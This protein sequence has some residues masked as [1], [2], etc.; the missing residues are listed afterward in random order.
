[1]ILTKKPVVQN[2][3]LRTSSEQSLQVLYGE[4][5]PVTR[6][7]ALYNAF[8]YPTKIS[9]EAIALYIASHTEPEDTVFD[10]FAGS[11]TTGLAALLCG[12]PPIQLRQEA[13]RLGLDPK[14]GPRNAILY[15][16]NALGAFVSQTLT[17]PPDPRQF[18]EAASQVL[19]D[20]KREFG[21]LYSA[22]DPAGGNGSIRY[23]VWSDLLLCSN[24]ESPVG[25][26][27]ECVSVNPAQ[28]TSKFLCPS[29]NQNQSIGMLNR[30]LDHT[31]DDVL[32]QFTETRKRKMARIYG[33]SGSN[34]WSR[35]PNRQDLE[36]LERVYAEDIPSC[37]PS[38][39]IPWGDLYRRGYHHG[40]SHVHHFYTRRN[41]IA[42]GRLWEK[43]SAFS[44]QLRD[45]LRFWLLSYNSSHATIMSRVIAKSGQRDLVVTGAQ[46]GVLYVSGLPVEKNV[47]SGL[48]RKLTSIT[49]AFN[50]IHGRRGHVSVHEKSSRTI[51]LPNASVDYIFADPPFGANI[52]YSEIS[53]LNES[54]LGRT[55]DVTDEA[56]VS[57]SQRKSVS[58]YQQIL[59]DVFSEFNRILK[60]NGNATL[61]FHSASSNV[62]N[63]LRE[64]YSE[65]GFS[66]AQ[67]GILDKKQGSFKQV[68]TN[69]SVKGDP[70]LLL[71]KSFSKS[72]NPFLADTWN[73]A[74][75]L[76][77]EA[78]SLE[79]AEQTPERLYSRLVNYFLTQ[80][81][82]VPIDAHEYYSWLIARQTEPEHATR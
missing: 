49:G 48:E 1:M 77:I 62:W 53:I 36:L 33:A 56:I 15:E 81:Q 66:V 51:A 70:I 9:P 21:W 69:G 47:F 46:P 26:W 43:A 45:A 73:I 19:G 5:L 20:T 40:I 38:V 29:C 24:C 71:R 55:T 32:R 52:P 4:A 2:Q 34:K 57:K 13:F 67:T 22:S 54:W 42:F 28:I 25:L 41:L 18:Q 37:V 75:K 60:P 79:L 3:S 58:N 17:N 65:A 16:I 39:P 6:T 8:P 72:P 14:W 74:E 10:G 63:A 27:D 23:V 76:R 80:N 11:G 35:E 64:A 7:G 44:P 82:E 31:Y 50:T 30:V 68:T 12:D 59:T 78:L 61:V